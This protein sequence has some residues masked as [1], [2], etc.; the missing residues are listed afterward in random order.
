MFG[1]QEQSIA[2]KEEL[3]AIYL[4]LA[5]ELHPDV[6]HGVQG[7]DKQTAFQA[8]QHCYQ[9]LLREHAKQNEPEW[10]RKLRED[11]ATSKDPFP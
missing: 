4:R 9:L 2:S 7:N 5:K 10:L 1:C 6:L 11:Y 3:K 8:L